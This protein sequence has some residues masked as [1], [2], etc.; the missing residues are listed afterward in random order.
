MLVFGGFRGETNPS[1]RCPAGRRAQLDKLAAL[2]KENA[3]ELVAA[4]QKDL[5]KPTLEAF[6]TDIAFVI[7]EIDLARKNLARWTKPEKV[8]T[9]LVQQ[10]AKARVVRE[11]L[12]VVLIIAPWNY[13]VQ[14]LLG[15]L[16]GALAAGNCAVLKPSEITANTSAV[17]AR[18]V[19]KYL[20]PECVAIVEGGVPETSALLEQRYD[21]IFYTGNGAVA[22]VIMEAAAVHLTPMTLELGGK[23][24][25]IVDKDAKLDVTA[26]RIAWGKFLNAGQTCVA[27][28][29]LLVH[30]S[31]EDELIEK[32]GAAV[33]EFYG[34]DPRQT[35]DFGRIASERHHQ[36]LAALL[37]DA[38]DVVVGGELVQGERYIAP[39]IVRNVRPDAKIMSEEIFGPILPVLTVKDV[40]EAIAFVNEREKPLALYLFTED[41]DTEQKVLERTSSGGACVNATIWH[42]ANPNLPFG[43]VGPSGMGSYHGRDGFETFSHKKSVVTKS[44]KLDPKVAYPPYTKMKTNLVKRMI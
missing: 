43:G 3:D 16:V 41:A 7:A 40:D 4:L 15:P 32:L 30:E 38:G 27:P 17:L 2:C 29:Y 13:P 34:D 33:R 37:E 23:S 26:R 28:D 20:D 8:R 42:L 9:P 11:P 25:C 44:T 14:L 12:G 19:P 22:R 1:R 21:H 18:L 36:R 10:L 6:T 35:D 24:P 31:I 5:G 39:T